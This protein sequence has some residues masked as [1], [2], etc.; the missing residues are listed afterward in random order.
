MLHIRPIAHKDN[1]AI[2][3]IIKDVL[4]SFGANKE[5]FASKD[6]ETDQMFETYQQPNTIYFVA[7][8]DGTIIG[9]AGIG[10]L[11]GG[12]ENICELQKMYLLPQSRRQGIGKALMEKCLEFALEAGYHQC[13][14]ETLDKMDAAKSLYKKY[15]FKSLL[16]PLGSTG[17]YG[18]NTWLLKDLHE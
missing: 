5:G 18:C 10:K 11:K 2:S 15:G 6:P 14:I 8:L 17:H 7:V 9:G 13:Y 12:T 16:K 3:H 1:E 4:E